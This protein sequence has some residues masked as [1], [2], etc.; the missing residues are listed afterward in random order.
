MF[1]DRSGREPLSWKPVMNSQESSPWESGSCPFWPKG[2]REGRI[3]SLRFCA[4]APRVSWA[5]PSSHPESRGSSSV[6][7]ELA[8]PLEGG[9]GSGGVAVQRKCFLTITLGVLSPGARV[10][11]GVR[12]RL[13][14]FCF[15]IFAAFVSFSPNPPSTNRPF[16]TNGV[17]GKGHPSFPLLRGPLNGVG[18]SRSLHVGTHD[19]GTPP[20][21]HTD[22]H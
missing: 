6:P 22:V 13:T 16:Q 18:P 5:S 12:L 9:S 19:T 14:F 15:L 21:A 8:K 20:S 4:L 17:W 10:T 3:Q 7:D 2:R 1:Q 11:E